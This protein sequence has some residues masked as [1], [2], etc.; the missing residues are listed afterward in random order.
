MYSGFTYRFLSAL[1]AVA[2]FTNASKSRRIAGSCT[3]VTLSILISLSF[4]RNEV[5]L[6]KTSAVTSSCRSRRAI[7]FPTSTS[8]LLNSSRIYFNGVA[9]F[10]KLASFS[11]TS[12]S[13]LSGSTSQSSL[14]R[15][16]SRDAMSST[17]QTG[18]LALDQQLDMSRTAYSSKRTM[19]RAGNSGDGSTVEILQ[20]MN[21][22]R[23]FSRAT[24]CSSGVISAKCRFLVQ[25]RYVHRRA[26]EGLSTQACDPRSAKSVGLERKVNTTRAE[27]VI[28]NFHCC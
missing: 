3:F 9:N 2:S 24:A 6:A 28:G 18:F 26:W 19:Y 17:Y 10:S 15:S 27:S 7:N 25:T 4:S 22:V 20:I 16:M 8:N 12:T 11:M 13:D 21:A 1:R 5:A 14:V 23:C